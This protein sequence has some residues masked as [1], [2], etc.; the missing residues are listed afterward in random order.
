MSL[1]TFSDCDFDQFYLRPRG[2]TQ[3]LL[4]FSVVWWACFV[5]VQRVDSAEEDRVDYATQIRPIFTQHCTACHG[6]VKQAGD[7]SFVYREQLANVIEPGS[8][9]DSYLFERIIEEDDES[10]MPPPD[11]GPRLN[12]DDVELIRK[13]ID[14][15]AS[16]G[17]HWAYR[18]PV[19]SAGA[20]AV[21][22]PDW[23][24]QSLDRFVLQKLDELGIA[25][26]RDE[27]PARWL[28][29]VSL[30]LIGLPPTLTERSEFL[31]NLENRGEQAY[32]SVVDRLLASPHFGERW[33]TV[34]LDQVRYADSRGSGEDTPRDIWKY[35]DWVI[36][37]LNADMPYDQFTIKQLAGDLL[38]DPTL[39]DRLATAVHRLTHS[40]EEGGTDDEEFRVAAVL[41]RISTTW[42][43]W[44]GTSIGCVQCHDHPYDP[45]RHEEFYE[46]MD[47]FNNTADQDLTEEWPLLQVPKDREMYDRATEL[48]RRI[49]EL[50]ESIWRQQWEIAHQQIGWHPLRIDKA[51]TSNATKVVVDSKPTHDEYR[52]TGTVSSGPWIISEVDVPEGVGPITGIRFT[53]LPTDEE[54]AES[55]AEVGFV[56]SNV[57]VRIL[58][59]NGGK[60]SVIKIVKLVGDEPFPFHEPEKS[61]QKGNEGFGAYTRIFHPR[62]VVLIPESPV[63]MVPG[64]KLEIRVRY[65]VFNLAAFVLVAQ[66]GYYAVTDDV[67]LTPIAA[68]TDITQQQKKLAEVHEKRKEIESVPT[69][70]LQERPKHLARESRVFI[71]GLFLT[72][73][74]E[75]DADVPDS[76]N[77][78]DMLVPDRFALAEWLVSAGNPLTARVA[79]NRFWAQMFGVGLVLT[80][81]DFGAAGEAPSHPELLDDLAVRFREDYKWSV[82]K[83]LKEMALSRTYRQSA[84][85][86]ESIAESD[87]Q[88]RWLAR[89][90]RHSLP[91]ETIRDQMLAISGLLN[92]ERYGEPVHPP[93]PSGVWRARRGTWKTPPKGDPARYRRS[94]YTYVKRSVPFPIF[95][96]FDAPSRDQ[97]TPRRQR[98]NTPLQSLMLLN[99]KAFVECAEAFAKLMSEHADE[100][101]KQLEFGFLTATLRMPSEGELN[102]LVNL[103]RNVEQSE[104]GEIAMQAVAGVLL[105]LDEIIV[106]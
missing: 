100:I 25:P 46:F 45:F 3:L 19:R 92:P 78:N 47:L 2:T 1:T 4:V 24:R 89:G 76:L 13:W 67:A 77:T 60:P 80:E 32:E 50:K 14:Q 26:A 81:E 99:D 68:D 91:A 85:I 96:S 104:N 55:S 56:M 61:L 79:V 75:V 72:K 42:Q 43:T 63:T 9:E 12:A 58:P 40:N 23:G 59:P 17:P 27:A 64:A 16:W 35:R 93:L 97:C 69:P 84:N 65:G 37:A 98:S 73:G 71:R 74:E 103:Y 28:R 49:I 54:A 82:K 33:A 94:V 70:I 51:R 53:A 5:A 22:N 10:R 8:A 29:R 48:D 52:T 83:L 39:S 106:K 57:E 31:T 66:R 105:N 21:S 34:W 38:P 90:P 6:G 30:D 88:N 95:T 20:I 7:L 62:N 41:D 86:R 18:L 36:E 44:Q 11:H 87:P 15:G 101:S 102:Q